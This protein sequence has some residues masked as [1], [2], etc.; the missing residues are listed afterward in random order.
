LL[1]SYYG[2]ARLHPISYMT[3]EWWQ[4][5]FTMDAENKWIPL[6]DLTSVLYYAVKW[7]LDAKGKLTLS[8]PK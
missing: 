4:M 1:L 2:V 6:P 5:T 3:H 8:I 7:E